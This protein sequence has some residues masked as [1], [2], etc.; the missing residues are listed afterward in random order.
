VRVHSSLACLAA[1][2]ALAA[3]SGSATAASRVGQTVDPSP[4]NC[5]PEDTFLQAVSPGDHFALPFDGVITSWSFHGGSIVPSPLKLKVGTVG[6]NS[7]SIVGESALETPVANR[8]NTFS[9]RIPAQ[10]RDLIGFYFPSPANGAQCA[11]PNQ[12]G[13]TDVVALGDV[14]P[15]MSASPITNE[16]GHLDLAANLEPDCDRDGL[17]DE[18]QD[19]SLSTCPTCKGQRSTIVGTARKDVLSGATGRDVIVGLAGNDKLSGLGGND[20]ICGGRG[21]D[22]LNGGPGKDVLLGQGGK[23]KCTGGKGKD[24]ASGCEKKRSI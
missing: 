6:T 16:S 24:S 9:T 23:D 8:V 12:P 13:Y 10:A 22:K 14:L 19:D 11:A 5:T 7:M 17:G 15:G 1:A 20:L 18:T 3:A 2:A 21:K 4:S